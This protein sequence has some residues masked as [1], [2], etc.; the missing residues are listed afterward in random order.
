MAKD[1]KHKEEDHL[2]IRTLSESTGHLLITLNKSLLDRLNA[3]QYESTAYHDVLDPEI[4]IDLHGRHLTGPEGF[5]HGYRDVADVSP[6]LHV[7]I[8]NSS[9]IVD[10]R[11]DRATVLL[12]VSLTGYLEDT[13]R[14]GT[15][16]SCWR[17]CG[18]GRWTCYAY[19]MFYGIQEFV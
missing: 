9:A 15:I 6:G 17:R 12:H 1:P 5:V 7:T 14:A 3:R 4:H 8:T 18:D 13:R 19:H 16:L 10:E 2:T 11:L